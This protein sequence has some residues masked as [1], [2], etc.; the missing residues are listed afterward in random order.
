[1]KRLMR[2]AETI[3]N[4]DSIINKILDNPESS[5]III[6]YIDEYCED[7]ISEIYE[8]N[9][10]NLTADDIFESIEKDLRDTNKLNDFVEK[11]LD[12]TENDVLSDELYNSQD[13]KEKLAEELIEKYYSTIENVLL[14]QIKIEEEIHSEY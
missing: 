14:E 2:V 13:G 1:M 5:N 9:N 8:K 11:F 4:I 12:L 7:N 3:N 6:N 10:G